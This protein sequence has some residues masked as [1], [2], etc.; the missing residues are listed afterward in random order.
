MGYVRR[1]QFTLVF[2]DPEFDGLEVVARSASLANYLIVAQLQDDIDAVEAPTEDSYAKVP[3]LAA[4]LAEH[5][6]SWNLEEC[7]MGGAHGC[8]DECPMQPVPCDA[9]GLLAQDLALFNALAVAWMEAAA[10]VTG[11]KEQSSNDT[12]PALVA[13]LPM[14]PLSPSQA[15]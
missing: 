2:A 11:P 1:R 10:G 13:S 6:V 3:Q 4:K 5:L 8:S 9:D 7:A 12:P 15:S 14:E